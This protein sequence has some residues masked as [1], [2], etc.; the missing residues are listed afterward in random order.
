M[1]VNRKQPA[2]KSRLGFIKGI[3]GIHR[4]MWAALYNILTPTRAAKDA[5][6]TSS[7]RV[8]L[9]VVWLPAILLGWT[10]MHRLAH[11]LLATNHAALW[12][13][14]APWSASAHSASSIW[15]GLCL[16]LLFF[17]AFRSLLPSFPMLFTSGFLNGL[18][19]QPF[20]R[21]FGHL[22]SKC[23]TDSYLPYHIKRQGVNGSEWHS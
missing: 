22:K 23:K 21:S 1:A 5:S 10:G 6:Y 8:G 12:H 15:Q 4:G 2:N 16:L 19:C 7:G 18:R 11:R 3:P 17:G 20:G 13:Y 9:C 14:H